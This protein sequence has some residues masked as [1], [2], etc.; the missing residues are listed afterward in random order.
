MDDEAAVSWFRKAAAQGSTRAHFLL[1]ECYDYGYG[2]EQDYQEAARAAAEK[3]RD[4]IKQ[5]VTIL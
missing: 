4:E 2:V 1:G 5:Y 3:M